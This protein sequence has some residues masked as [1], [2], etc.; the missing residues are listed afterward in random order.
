ML[1]KAERPLVIVGQGAI[2]R[3][4]GAAVLGL[5]A[6]LAQAVGAVTADWNG[7]AV[8]H[9]AAARVG[10]LD[11]GF[12]PGARR[13][14]MPPACSARTRRA[15]PAR[16]RRARPGQDR[17]QRL[18]RLYRHAWRRRRA[19]RQRHPAGCRLHREVGHLRQHR[20]PRADDQPRR[21]RAG[22]GQGGLGDP[23]GAVGRARPAPAVRFAGAIARQALCG[24]SAS[25]PHRPDRAGQRRRHRQA[26]RAR[27]QD[28]ART[29]FRS[30]VKDFYL[31][32]PIARAS[33]V[34]A[35]CSALARSGFKQAAE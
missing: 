32:N 29:A 20:G 30:P 22:R 11:I 23:A 31:T 8:L 5:A 3:A 7:F 9:T 13:R 28:S 1:Q 14:R 27:R 21:L 24:L 25:R 35:E 2:A 10:G 17:Q 15:V 16:R 6:K 18:R 33:A 19:P 4:D 26:R 34:M 12:V